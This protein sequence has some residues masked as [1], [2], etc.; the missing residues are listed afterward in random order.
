MI[1]SSTSQCSLAEAVKLYD[2]VKAVPEVQLELQRQQIIDIML[3]LLN[4][5][6]DM[7][8]LELWED[9][10]KYDEA[11]QTG[12]KIILRPMEKLCQF[13]HITLG[14]VLRSNP[15]AIKHVLANYELFNFIQMSFTP[16]KLF[17]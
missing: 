15:S 14:L 4:Q 17:I 3:F 8:F 1:T 13:L 2:Q 12:K 5:L 7:Y 10:S 11:M 6:F 16:W 9:K